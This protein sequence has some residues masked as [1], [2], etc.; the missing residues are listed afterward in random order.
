MVMTTTEACGLEGAAAGVEVMHRF[1]EID[2]TRIF[3]RDTGPVD[4]PTILLLHGFPTASHQFRRL[5]DT[6]GH[7]CRMVAPDYPGFGYSDPF[8]SARP[9]EAFG[10]TFERLTDTVERFCV[11]LRLD[12]FIVYVFDFGGPVGMR[13]ATR[14]PGWVAGLVVQN[15]NA[16]EAGLSDMARELLTLRP[17]AAGDEDRIRSILVPEAV[18]GQYLT[19][20]RNPEAVAPDGWSLDQH[21]LSQPGREQVQI[22][23]AFDYRT[24]VALYPQWHQWLRKWRPPTLIAWGRGDPFFLEA[25]AHSYLRD[26][27]DAELHLFDTGHFALEE[28]LPEIS[29]L[30]ADFA[31]RAWRRE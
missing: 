20:V 26:L 7:R 9:G 27:P 4:G 31:E 18:R 28:R 30:L 29:A 25:G 14:H 6:I 5:I 24:N 10:T 17:D 19:G 2:G 22:D 3:Y 8:V 21:F 15:A 12:R 23:L 11:E 16:Y 1:V 13:L